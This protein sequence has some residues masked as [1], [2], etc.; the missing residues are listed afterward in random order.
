MNLTAPGY[1]LVAVVL[2][3]LAAWLVNV[4]L[5][6]VPVIAWHGYNAPSMAIREARY[7]KR[8]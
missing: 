8:R 6:G 5:L 7:G 2:V 4:R 1:T 3:P